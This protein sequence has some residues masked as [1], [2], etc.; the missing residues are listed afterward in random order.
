MSRTGLVDYV[1]EPSSTAYSRALELAAEMAGSG[2]VF[3][4]A[5]AD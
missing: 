3:P 1:S 4:R 5:Y 2:K